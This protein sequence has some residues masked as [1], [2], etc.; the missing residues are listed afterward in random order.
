MKR[1]YLEIDAA[2][3]TSTSH[4][5]LAPSPLGDTIAQGNCESSLEQT[6]L[7][8]A[9]AVA[10]PSSEPSIFLKTAFKTSLFPAPAAANMTPLEEFRTLKVRVILS[11]GC[12][13]RRVR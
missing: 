13:E 3:A 6:R 2:A 1:F 12:K 4:N 9:E 11:G 8:G 5:R 10:G 7:W